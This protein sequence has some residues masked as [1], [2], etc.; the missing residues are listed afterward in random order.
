MFS[1]NKKTIIPEYKQYGR[2]RVISI[3]VII[4]LIAGFSFGLYFI[5]R[6]IYT[7]IDEMQNIVILKSEL[8]MEIIDFDK[9]NTIKKEWEEKHETSFSINR[10]PFNKVEIPVILATSTS[11]TPSITTSTQK[12]I[13]PKK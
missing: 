5:Y 6:N 13:I 3:F 7:A 11:S 1:Q 8:A 10:D 4:I 9:Y 2:L 12:N